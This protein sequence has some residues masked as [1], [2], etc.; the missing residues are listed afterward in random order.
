MPLQ[1]NMAI[2]SMI[3]EMMHKYRR[4]GKIGNTKPD[5]ATHARLIATAV[6]YDTKRRPAK[7]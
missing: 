1:K 4:T 7:E 5:S 2:G 6:A 3:S